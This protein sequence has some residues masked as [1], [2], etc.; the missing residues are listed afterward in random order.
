MT[1]LVRYSP[2][3]VAA[4]LAAE[5]ATTSYS[6]RGYVYR[7]G[8]SQVHH[9]CLGGWRQPVRVRPGRDRWVR[10][11]KNPAGTA[12]TTTVY[13]PGQDA[14]RT[15]PVT[16]SPTTAAVRYYS[17]DG[18]VVASRTSTTGGTTGLSWIIANYHACGSLTGRQSRQVLERLGVDTQRIVGRVKGREPVYQLPDGRVITRD[19][20]GHV[21]SGAWKVA[22]RTEDLHLK[23]T[24]EG[25]FGLDADGNLVRVGP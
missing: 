7:L 5:T 25:T 17:H 6:D 24:R 10:T 2:L 11:A 8:S 23:R 4:G 1:I 14:S 18:D 16:G 22:G 9:R 13:L 12:T 21:P 19:L 15:V 20:D 3:A